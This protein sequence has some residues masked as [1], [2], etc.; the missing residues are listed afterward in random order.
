MKNKKIASL[1]ANYVFN[2]STTDR[3]FA[4]QLFVEKLVLPE[5]CES[6]SIGVLKEAILK[7]LEK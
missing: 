7:K 5:G 4:V 1:V 6:Y 3:D 2:T